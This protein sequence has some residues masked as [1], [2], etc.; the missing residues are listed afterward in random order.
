MP[1]ITLEELE[2]MLS[3]GVKMIYTIDTSI[4]ISNNFRFDGDQ[5]SGLC[6]GSQNA[7][8][9]IPK[10]IYDE[11]LK[12]YVDFLNDAQ[13]KSGSSGFSVGS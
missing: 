2:E 9:V 8:F 4:F 5:L 7:Q 6:M 13:K 11:V 10:I 12:N 3:K 1:K